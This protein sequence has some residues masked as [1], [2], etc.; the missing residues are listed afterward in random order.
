MKKIN[1][2]ISLILGILLLTTLASLVSAITIK[3]ISISPNLVEPGEKFSASIELENNFDSNVENVQVSLDL[4]NVPIAPETSS[5]VFAEE[6]KEDKSKDFD[7][8][9][10]AQ[11]DAEAGV[12]KFPVLISYTLDTKTIQETGTISVTINAK[13]VLDLNAEGF[14]LAGKNQL[15]IK[16]T[17]SGLAKAR[18][19]EIS[20]G[21]GSYQFLSSNKIYIGDLNS[22]D[23]DTFSFDIYTSKPGTITIPLNIK[24]KDFA[25]N[26]YEESK[27]VFIRVY[28]QEEALQ[29]GLVTKSKTGTYIVI[30]V[31]LIILYVI[32]RKIRKWLKNRKANRNVVK[33]KR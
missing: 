22:D 1:I 29:L 2:W 20:A 9:L 33:E 11:S 27:D 12:Y 32:Y 19:L 10:I 18:F 16:I 15:N 3:D 6:I 31:V 30:A 13:P 17:N 21:T 23:F 8:D 24:Y 25:N 26:D 28:S 4:S 14:L 7:F 5:S